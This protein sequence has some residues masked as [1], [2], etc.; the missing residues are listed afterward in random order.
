MSRKVI[1][2]NRSVYHKLAKVEVEIPN[3]VKTED[4][5]QWIFDNPQLWDDDLEDTIT[6]ANH[7]FGLG[8]VNGMEDAGADS[9]T[10][11]DVLEKDVKDIEV[12][13]T[14]VY[15]GHL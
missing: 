3:D 15:G 13:Y 5:Q 2:S 8:L 6:Y 10:R 4:V 12:E 7:E 14:Q 9:E 11:Y 1:I